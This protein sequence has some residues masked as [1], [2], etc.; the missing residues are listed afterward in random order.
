ME[1]YLGRCLDSIVNQTFRDFKVIMVDDGSTDKS[2]EIAKEYEK[3]YGYTL[4]HQENRGLGG[5]RNTGIG[6]TQ[7]KYIVFPDS[8]DWLQQDYLEKL[9]AAAEE[10]QADVVWCG[11]DCVWDSGRR[12]RRALSNLKSF[13]RIDKRKLLCCISYVTWDKIFR[14]KLFDGISFPEHMSKQDYA[15][16]PRVIAKANK[17][18]G[19]EDVL[20]N[21]YFRSDSATNGRKVQMNLLKA[22]HILEESEMVEEYGDVLESYYIRNVICTLVWEMMGNK[23]VYFKQ[24]KEI[25]SEG[26]HKYPNFKKSIRLAHIEWLRKPFAYMICYEHFNLAELYV[27]SYKTAQGIFHS[28]RG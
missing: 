17:V 1:K 2:Y 11:A 15:C 4:V 16:I 3:K 22:Q 6:M 23:E 21:Y 18:V 9:V 8:D 19:I 20:Y 27:K 10:Y 28:I 24:V 14:T 7:T 25:V 12:K 26:K 13:S 5:A